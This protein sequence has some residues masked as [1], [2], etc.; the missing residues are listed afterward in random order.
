LGRFE[1]SEEAY[2]AR[3]A[4]RFGTPHEQFH[5]EK[6]IARLEEIRRYNTYVANP[7]G[8]RKSFSEFRRDEKWRGYKSPGEIGNVAAVQQTSL[9]TTAKMLDLMEKF[10][11][12]VMPRLI[13]ALDERDGRRRGRNR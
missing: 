12:G 10:I 6:Y 2:A 11:V 9:Q 7:R 4:S 13:E 3:L 8:K 1:E 5:P